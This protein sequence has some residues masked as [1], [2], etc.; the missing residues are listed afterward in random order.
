MRSPLLS[1]LLQLLVRLVLQT[2]PQNK[3]E[4][5][6]VH[7]L[8]LDMLQLLNASPEVRGP[9][10][11]AGLEVGDFLILFH[12]GNKVASEVSIL[13]ISQCQGRSLSSQRFTPPHFPCSYIRQH[14]QA[15]TKQRSI[16]RKG[17]NTSFPALLL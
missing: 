6:K 15:D 12:N 7:C 11:D 16:F 9:E 3:K 13:C 17:F 14:F 2:L 10:L 4:R 5:K 1:R 8:S